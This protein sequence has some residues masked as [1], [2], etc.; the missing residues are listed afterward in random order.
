[1]PVKKEHLDYSTQFQ[2]RISLPGLLEPEAIAI[3]LGV[4]KGLFSNEILKH[5]MIKKLYSVDRWANDRGHNDKEMQEAKIRLSKFLERSEIIQATFE[6]A[7]PMFEDEYF[8][9]VYVDGY[10]H[11]GYLE[12]L[13]SWWEKLKPNGLLAVHDYC[14]KWPNNVK[15][16]NNFCEL[17][18]LDNTMAT[19]SDKYYSWWA[20]K[21]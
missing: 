7:L 3:E 17:K 20:I 18:N 19:T 12:T 11:E 13:V 14:P 9:F 4:A 6:E 16:I 21:K 15:A 5:K 10:A 2:R 8:D 1:M